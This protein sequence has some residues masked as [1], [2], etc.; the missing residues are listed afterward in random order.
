MG[1]CPPNDVEGGPRLPFTHPSERVLGGPELNPEPE[2]PESCAMGGE[3]ICGGLPT[4][5]PEAGAFANGLCPW[6]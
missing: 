6:L 1:A 4:P 5:T 2:G 3:S